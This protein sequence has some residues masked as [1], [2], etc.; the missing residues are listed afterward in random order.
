MRFLLEE[1]IWM[2]VPPPGCIS[3]WALVSHTILHFLSCFPVVKEVKQCCTGVVMCKMATFQHA[4]QLFTATLDCAP[5]PLS[6][7]YRFFFFF[8]G[9]ASP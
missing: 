4:D 5:K 9:G 2:C 3:G 7:V 1:L 8:F 6:A